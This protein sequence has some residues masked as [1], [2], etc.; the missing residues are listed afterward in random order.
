MRQIVITTLLLLSAYTRAAAIFLFADGKTDYSIVLPSDASLSEKTA[1]DELRH[2]IR[3]IS[4]ARMPVTVGHASTHCI[5]VGWNE[6]CGMPRPENG[7]EGYTYRTVG[8]DLHIFGGSDRGTM[9][10]VFA[11]LEQ[12]LGVRWYTSKFTKVPTMERCELPELDHSERP[13]LRYR[14]D[15]CYEPLR[16][17]SWTAHNRLN[18]MHQTRSTKYGTFSAYWGIHTFHTLIPPEN[19]FADHPEY[20]S[21]YKGQRSDKAQLCLSNEDMR[22]ELV[23]N[24]EEAIRN[25]PGYWC[26][27]VSQNDNNKNCECAK[28]QELVTTYGGQSGALLWF[29]NKVA[30]EIRQSFP[31]VFIGTFAYQSTRRAPIGLTPEDNVVIRLC[32]IECCIAHPVGADPSVCPQNVSFADDLRNWQRLTPNVYIWNYSTCFYRYL[33]PFP[34]F[35]ALAANYQF[36][37]QSDGSADVVGDGQTRKPA[38]T[39]ADSN[40]IGVMEEGAHDAPWSEFSE[41]KQWMIAKLLWNPWQDTD[42]LAAI[43]IDDYYGTAAP[44][45]RQYYD[46]CQSRA[47]DHHFTTSVDGDSPLYDDPFTDEALRLTEQAMATAS[48]DAQTLL[49]TKRLAAQVYFL[50]LRR[51]YKAATADGTRQKLVDIVDN[52]STIVRESGYTLQA[53][54]EQMEKN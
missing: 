2:Y 49:R 14:L 45:V 40:V 35:R 3:Q 17:Y 39:A 26:Y 12:E 10:G 46:L 9:Y 15:F 33:L 5:Y 1:A 6:K 22:S 38:P 11:F 47:D 31:D 32:D 25:N 16:D 48:D 41:L 34:C 29:V 4:G 20:F 50:K 42:S 7:D 28:C 52:D 37:S 8:G 23:R 18:T 21:L 13:A 54:L 53:V 27:D 19:Y 43:F 36:F 44:F 30:R 24:L 51:D